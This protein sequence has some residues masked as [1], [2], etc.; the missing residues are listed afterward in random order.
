MTD[1][2]DPA[3]LDLARRRA[4]SKVRYLN[5]RRSNAAPIELGR[6][7]AELLAYGL[8]STQ[9]AVAEGIGESPLKVSRCL[10][11]VRVPQ[12]IATVFGDRT[13]SRRTATMLAE[14]AARIGENKLLENA[15]R[16]GTRE[17]LPIGEILRALQTGEV[18]EAT[19]AEMRLVRNPE[20]NYFR[21]YLPRVARQDI[22]KLEAKIR[23]A[24]QLLL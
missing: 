1:I 8:W 17:D 13:V 12:Q 22:G 10:K 20:E 15:R 18:S 2:A 14:I 6:F 4:D 9:A 11:L 5:L 16:L 21:L 23:L 7:F 24:M 19:G 3:V